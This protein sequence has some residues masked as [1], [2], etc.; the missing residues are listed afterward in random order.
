MNPPPVSHGRL[1]L[2]VSPRRITLARLI[3]FLATELEDF[4]GWQQLESNRN[5][6]YYNQNL[7]RFLQIRARDKCDAVQFDREIEHDSPG[8]HDIGTFPADE[9][10]LIV[11]GRKFRP[12]EPIYTMEC[13]R[14][15]SPVGSRQREYLTSESGHPPRGGVQRYKMG[16]HGAGL[17]DAGIIGYVEEGTPEAW[18]RKINGWVD[19]LIRNPVDSTVVWKSADRL[20]P[21]SGVKKGKRVRVSKSECIRVQAGKTRLTHFHVNMKL[22]AQIE[23]AFP[24]Q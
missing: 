6:N 9:I 20:K 11:R 15:P 18:Q 10:G 5:E 12:R 16:I 17:D 4:P 8:A 24:G 1:K 14:L 23:L 19:Q 22:G 2:R 13:K 21:Y 3:E 7:N